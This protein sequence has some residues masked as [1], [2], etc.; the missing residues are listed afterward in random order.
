MTSFAC[1]LVVMPAALH[2]TN[3]PA[4]LL[5]SL[6]VRRRLDLPARQRQQRSDGRSP[7]DVPAFRS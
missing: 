4:S 1:R 2:C 6:A 5:S 7:I 3:R